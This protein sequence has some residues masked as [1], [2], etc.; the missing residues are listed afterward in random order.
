M[1]KKIIYVLV[2]VAALVLVV[3]SWYG[4]LY[5]TTPAHI[6]KPGF[7]HF[8]FRTQVVIDGKAVDFSKDKFQQSY[9][10]DACSEDVAPE[11][12]HFHDHMDQMTHIHWQGITGGE[13]LKYFGWNFIGGSDS[14]LGRRY[15]QGLLSMSTVKI[16]G[17]VL[18][19]LPKD[20]NFY[21]YIG[22]NDSYEQ[23]KWEDFLKQDLETFFGKQSN[24]EPAEDESAFW[25]WLFPKA[26][27]H[28]GVVD[29]NMGTET[30][31][32]EAEL[33]RINNLLGNVVIFVQ[34]DAPSKEQIQARFDNLVPLQD[35]AC[36]G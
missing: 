5:A 15:D 16:F 35:S 12:M 3:A 29:E 1:K 19:A 10:K 18:P 31:L 34:K 11:P 22:D 32:D 13:V 2:A 23:K 33:T 4:Y 25:D 20:A 14:S 6:R 26:T 8:H 21:V 27:A 30:E 7:E 24:I 17:K 36:G 9:D 28:G